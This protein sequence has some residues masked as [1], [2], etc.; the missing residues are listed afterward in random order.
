MSRN[1]FAPGIVLMIV[2]LVSQFAPFGKVE[3]VHAAPTVTFDFVKELCNARWQS[4]A[5]T[6][7][8]PFTDGDA[9]GFALALPSPKLENGAADSA[10]GILVF[11]QKKYNG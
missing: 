7:P 3:P 1:R 11:P 5:G 10:P 4:G 2:I 6:L 9:R 8:C